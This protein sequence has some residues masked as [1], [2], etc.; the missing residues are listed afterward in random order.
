MKSLA[1]LP[2]TPIVRDMRETA[3]GLGIVQALLTHQRILYTHPAEAYELVEHALILLG[4]T[5]SELSLNLAR[6]K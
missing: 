5:N 3:R 6:R 4:A 1:D 2:L